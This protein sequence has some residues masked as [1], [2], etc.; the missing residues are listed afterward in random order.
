MANII[1]LKGE[2]EKE[3][4]SYFSENIRSLVMKENGEVDYNKNVL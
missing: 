1:T 2:A 4:Y 3:A